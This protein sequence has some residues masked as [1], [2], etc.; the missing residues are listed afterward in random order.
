M[1]EVEDE[2]T[3]E[4]DGGD[5]PAADDEDAALDGELEPERRLASVDG[6]EDEYHG[7]RVATRVVVGLVFPWAVG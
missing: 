4:E 7:V 3:V 5:H 6:D 2:G 1:D